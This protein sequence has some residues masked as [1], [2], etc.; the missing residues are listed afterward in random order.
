MWAFSAALIG[1]LTMC[2]ALSW[3][4]GDTSHSHLVLQ[5]AG[6]SWGDVW[7]PDT[8]SGQHMPPAHSPRWAHTR[9]E[10]RGLQ[11]CA[12]EERVVCDPLR[13]QT[14]EATEKLPDTSSLQVGAGVLQP[15]KQE[16]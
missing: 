11:A 9:P 7:E 15:G 6:P 12:M 4:Q 16:S 8:Q 13:L 2:Q 14:E 3:Q 10:S 1:A 5:L